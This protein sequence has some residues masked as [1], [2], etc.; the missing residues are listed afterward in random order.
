MTAPDFV[1][2]QAPSASAA[3]P[4]FLQAAPP[5]LSPAVSPRFGLDHYHLPSDAQIMVQHQLSPMPAA[6]RGACHVTPSI[7]LGSMCTPAT[8]SLSVRI[9]VVDKH[10]SCPSSDC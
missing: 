1:V 10:V 2:S 8:C 3:D 6:C 5:Q 4:S 7:V 9:T